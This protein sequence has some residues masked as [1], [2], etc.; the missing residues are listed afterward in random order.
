MQIERQP[1]LAIRPSPM[2]PQRR[3]VMAFIHAELDAGRPFP[4][5]E[6]IAAHIGW[7][8]SQSAREVLMS[9]AGAGYLTYAANPPVNG[10][11]TRKYVF[12]LA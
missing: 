3:R 11:F 8:N 6:Q 10:R 9:L 7:R 5:M 2:T 1:R 4:S 12:Q